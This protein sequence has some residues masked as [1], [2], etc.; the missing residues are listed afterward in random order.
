MIPRLINLV[1]QF[2]FYDHFLKYAQF[3]IS[4]DIC[5]RWVKNCGRTNLPYGVL[6]K[7]VDPWQ[8]TH[9]EQW[10]STGQRMDCLSR[11]NYSLI[12]PKNPAKF[13]ND[14]ISRS[15]HRL[16]IS[17]PN[18]TILV[19]FSSAEYVL[20]NDVKN[21]I[22]LVCKVLEIRRSHLFGTRGILASVS[23]INKPQQL[24]KLLH[25]VTTLRLYYGMVWYG[26]YFP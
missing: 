13:E 25:S 26:I 9:T 1:E 4:L 12:G 18:L 14:C 19:S 23:L 5:N 3:Q 24:S 15:V 22:F 17:Q 7:P 8:K 10:A 16:Q 21:M 2:W 6:W 11:L 20:S